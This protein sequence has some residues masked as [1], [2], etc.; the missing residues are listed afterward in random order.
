MSIQVTCRCGAK[1]KAKD[2]FTGKRVK[3]PSC[4]EALQIPEPSVV[5]EPVS[6]PS[7]SDGFDLQSLSELEQA[8]TI[9]SEE[10]PILPT[11]PA[12]GHQTG[13]QTPRKRKKSRSGPKADANTLR[14]VVLVLIA[15]DAVQIGIWTLPSL[16]S[17]STLRLLVTSFGGWIAL[18]GIM[19]HIGLIV[20]GVGIF[21]GEEYGKSCATFSAGFLIALALIGL[22]MMLLVLG[23]MIELLGAVQI[24]ISVARSLLMGIGIPAGILICFNHPKWRD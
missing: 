22:P 2:E 7:P 20:G 24:V 10:Q 8:G 4:G 11:L 1:L 3:C 13:T 23:A 6:E 14:T 21:R 18:A 5:A 17:V 16:L 12:T 9:P 19:A 15:V